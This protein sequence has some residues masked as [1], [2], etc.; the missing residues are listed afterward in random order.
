MIGIVVV[1]HSPALARAAVDLAL[2]MGG[3]DPPAVRIAAGAGGGATGTDAVAIAAAIDEVATA[4]GVLVLMDLGSA[5]LSAGMALEFAASGAPVRLSAA[6]FVEG[7]IAA[8]VVAGSGAT[9]DAVDAEARR[10][11]EGKAAQLE[12]TAGASVQAAAGVADAERGAAPDAVAAS[13]TGVIRNP[14]GLHA[15]P[16]AVFVKAVGRHDAAVTVTDL[17]T[18][19]G[20]ASGASLISLMSLGVGQGARVRIDATGPDAAGVISE[21]QQLVA[22]GFGEV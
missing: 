3:D 8:V 6:P 18:G 1:S 14:S 10:A 11:L 19:K 21:L 20:P 7:L 13:F 15:R 16:A 12:G 9:L 2:E 5:I 17:G 22:D 4:D